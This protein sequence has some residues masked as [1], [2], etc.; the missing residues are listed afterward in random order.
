VQQI[1]RGSTM[2]QG[3]VYTPT[4]SADRLEECACKALPLKEVRHG[5]FS[6]RTGLL[7]RAAVGPI[8]PRAALESSPMPVT[9]ADPCSPVALRRP[10][11]QTPK[12]ACTLGFDGASPPP[13]P[14]VHHNQLMRAMESGAIAQVRAA[15]EANPDSAR[16]MFFDCEFEP[17]LCCAVRLRCSTEIFAL[18]LAHGAETQ[19]ANKCG[20]SPLTLLASREMRMFPR[21]KASSRHQSWSLQVARL[22]LQ[23]GASPNAH[24]AKG[25]LPAD[26][27]RLS[28]NEGLAQFF[29]FFHEAQACTLLQSAKTG[30]FECLTPDVV[31]IIC[32]YLA[33]PDFGEPSAPPELVPMPANFEDFSFEMQP[34]WESTLPF[35]LLP[36]SLV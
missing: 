6:D 14:R 4:R 7:P 15:L 22:I 1:V 13:A 9:E 17:V 8:L 10:A 3:L 29:D 33:P 30:F 25:R 34:L 11:P 12:N 16:S 28:K 35:W 32:T 20:Q 5:E 19:A 2:A 21:C 27:A 36:S 24:D 26:V 18:L 23:A 31:Q